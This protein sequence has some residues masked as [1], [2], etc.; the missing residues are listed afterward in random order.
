[1]N[2]RF[3]LTLLSMALLLV[4][5]SSCTGQDEQATPEAASPTQATT[6]TVIPTSAPPTATP[7]TEPVMRLANVDSLEIVGNADDP[8]HVDVRLRGALSNSCSVIGDIITEYEGDLITIAVLSAQEPS[9]P[10]QECTEALVPFDETVALTDVA[11]GSYTV[12]AHGL[13]GTFTVEEPP[14]EVALE[15]ATPEATTAS[16]SGRVWHDLC[17]GSGGTEG[18]P[19]DGCIITEENRIQANGLQEDEGGI[20]GVR[21]GI[22][23]GDCPA[24]ATEYALTDADG[25][26]SFVELVPGVYCLSI[27]SADERNQDVLLSGIWTSPQDGQ[28]QQTIPVEGLDVSGVDFGWDFEFLPA[29][30][31]DLETCEN[32]FEFV[33][34]LN[35]PDDTVFEPGDNFTKQWLLR[36][37][38]TCPWT[39]DYSIVFVGGDQM[40]APE[41]IPLGQSIVPGQ[42]LE[43]AIDMIAPAELGTYR[44][45][46]QIADAQGEPFGIDGLIEDAFWLRIIVSE[47][48][49]PTA[50]AS[51][52]SGTIGGVVWD[53]F[54]FNS[55]PGAG[56][57]EFP[58]DSGIFIA[59]GSL[60]ADE[61][62]LSEITISLASEACPAGGSLPSAARI[63]STTTTGDDGLYR[64]ENLDTGMYCIFM[65]ALSEDNV[66]FL[67]PGNWTW[68]AT[69]VGR[70]TF[71]LDP[72]E[73]ALDLDFGWDYAD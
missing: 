55:D 49:A 22:A 59:N 26:Y 70:Y 33:E 53:D 12:S 34:D 3:S 42:P 45:N 8:T 20:E 24:P 10:D 67:I 48:A 57:L 37:N 9:E 25:V 23:T 15:T 21:V 7:L 36:N 14:E 44:G 72:G 46:W 38:G 66:D 69:G 18:E 60:D 17:A 1:M 64:F 71:F 58:E 41:S 2:H 50:T 30:E 13:Q 43:V 47:Q 29:V 51:P 32:S 56:C 73:Q 6:P 68:P 4:I 54:C 62:V 35:I 61:E 63:L 16:L 31:V 39:A 28:A 5:M 27:D 11:P 19:A 65:D 52:N 40:S